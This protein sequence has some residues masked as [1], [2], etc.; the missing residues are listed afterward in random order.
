[1]VFSSPG[2]LFVFLPLLLVLYYGLRSELKNLVLLAAS[3][4]FYSWGEPKYVFLMLLSIGFNYLFALMIDAAE[5][6]PTRKLFA[7]SCVFLN[8]WFLV[9]FK[10]WDFL[11]GACNNLLALF[12]STFAFPLQRIALPIG[13]SFFTFQIMSYTIDVYRGKVAAQKNPFHLALYISLFPQ[14]IAGPIVRYIDVQNEIVHRTHTVELF[15]EGLGR[16][17]VGFSKK[18][19]IANQMSRVADAAFTLPVDQL[20]AP[21]AWAGLL[22]YAIQIFFDF[23]AY[24]DMAIGLGK[25]F[26]FHFLENFNYPY[27]ARTVKDFWRRWHISLSTWFRDYLYIPLGGN[28]KGPLCT[29]RNLLIVFF[30]TGFWHG[31][32]WNFIVWGLFYGVFLILE[33]GAWGKLID[34][35][36]VFV[37]HIYVTFIVMIG[38]VFFRTENLTHSLLYIRKMFVFADTRLSH[39]APYLNAEMLCW[40]L[41]GLLF[42]TPFARV[43][44]ERMTKKLESSVSMIVFSCSEL[45]LMLLSISYMAASNGYNPF[46]YFRF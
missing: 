40:F 28:R 20:S 43:L 17:S 30:V 1:M 39:L 31:A 45:L 15:A 42:C 36:P 8:V 2:F 19:L 29:Y 34:R 35:L 27:I 26:G 33:R 46:I 11:I 37:G 21:M 22:C 12:G 18:I 13:I 38:W 14:L 44:K 10:Y 7:A 25:M 3:L 24:S 5:Q 32:S 4:F 23:S 9:Y 41:I 16:F 6:A